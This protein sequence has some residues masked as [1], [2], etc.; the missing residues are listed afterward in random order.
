MTSTYVSVYATNACIDASLNWT[1]M[2][3]I[4]TTLNTR[5]QNSNQADN[6]F[7]SKTTDH[8]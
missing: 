2:R 5:Y 6:T 4:L 1:I 7:F 8:H 3:S